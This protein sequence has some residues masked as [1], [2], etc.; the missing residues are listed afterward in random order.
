MGLAVTSEILSIGGAYDL[1]AGR[2]W[3]SNTGS[4]TV[5]VAAFSDTDGV[6]CL[7]ND[8]EGPVCRPLDLLHDDI[9]P[10][11]EPLQV[12]D[13]GDR[14]REVTVVAMSDTAAVVCWLTS[15]QEVKNQRGMCKGLSYLSK[16]LAVG[17]ADDAEE[18]PQADGAATADF[19]PP[20]GMNDNTELWQDNDC[21]SWFS[22][23]KRDESNAMACYSAVGGSM[24]GRCVELTIPDPTTTVTTGTST[25]TSTSSVHTT[26][27]SSTTTLT[28]TSTTVTFT[29]VTTSTQTSSTTP[30]TT[31]AT[32]T[33]TTTPT[34]ELSG[35][36]SAF[37]AL[38]A[39]LVAALAAAQ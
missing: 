39:L 14:C 9:G 38:P 5:S 25:E 27:E 23:S 4:K 12:G 17:D 21:E 20:K 28:E 13:N 19:T 6:A 16:A 10:A 15:E 36:R 22:V 3:P 18:F 2:D 32:E 31:T 30:H 7:C 11:G 34:T 8:D 33:T 35:G 37:L 29:T 26:T 1:G 24:T